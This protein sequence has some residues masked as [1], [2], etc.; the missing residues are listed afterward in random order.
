MPPVA[1]A[2]LLIFLWWKPNE[3]IL[4]IVCLLLFDDRVQMPKPH[5]IIFIYSYV[6]RKSSLLVVLSLVHQL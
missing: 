1:A 3:L 6:V 5:F 2:A 4:L